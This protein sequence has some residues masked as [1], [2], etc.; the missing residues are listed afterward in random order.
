MDPLLD[1]GILLVA[2]TTPT[3]AK[4]TS[5]WMEKF[6]VRKN[7]CKY[8]WEIF[9][10]FANVDSQFELQASTGC[11]CIPLRFEYIITLTIVFVAV[12]F[13]RVL[14]R[15]LYPTVGI[16]SQDFIYFNF[17]QK[18][19][20]YNFEEKP[21]PCSDPLSNFALNAHV[22]TSTQQSNFSIFHRKIHRHYATVFWP[23]IQ[24]RRMER[25]NSTSQMGTPA[26]PTKIRSQISTFL[27][28]F[29][30][31][32]LVQKWQMTLIFLRPLKSLE[33]RA[34]MKSG[35][36]LIWTEICNN[37]R[38]SPKFYMHFAWT[39]MLIDKLW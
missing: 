22:S 4:F 28:T 27:T 31:H 24:N 14:P 12:A 3:L 19:F 21:Q 39:F 16:D 10:N 37:L 18:P 35:K 9:C 33:T 2:V 6:Y 8:C 11:D 17:G 36:V 32:L 20:M 26:S 30:I 29:W 25:T 23:T 15:E 13:S 38:N 5:L 1:L 7:Y 34:E